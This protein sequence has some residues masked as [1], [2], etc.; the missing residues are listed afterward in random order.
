MPIRRVQ[1]PTRS[2][3]RNGNNL[4]LRDLALERGFGVATA[5]ALLGVEM[6]GIEGTIAGI[7][8]VSAGGVDRVAFT[9]LS[10][11]SVV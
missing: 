3:G 1:S 2:S 11:A 10:T 9:P 6:S 5:A 4:I 7:S 8:E